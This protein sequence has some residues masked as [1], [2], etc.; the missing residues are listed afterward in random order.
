MTPRFA[1]LVAVYLGVLVALAVPLGRYV[2]RVFTGQNRTTARLLG[3]V[4]RAV[5]ALAHI[6]ATQEHPWRSY[7]MALV[8]FSFVTHLITYLVLRTQAF[9]PWNPTH[10]PNVP[11]WLAFNTTVGF[12]T[13]TAWESSSGE[14][15]VSALSQVLALVSQN[16]FAP[17]VAMCAAMALARG[18]ARHESPTVGNAWVDLVRAHLYVLVP[19]SIV[20]AIAFVSQGVVESLLGPAQWTTVD[21]GGQKLLR[22]PVAALEAIKLLGSNGEGYYNANSAHPWENPTALSNFVQLVAILILPAALCFTFGEMVQSRRHGAALAFA[23]AALVVVGAVAIAYF[24]QHGNPVLAGTGVAELSPNMEGKEVRFG[25]PDSAL[26]AEVTTAASCGAVD[27]MHD[28]YM[29]LGGLVP[30]L[31]MQVG[32]VVFGG[33]GCG[34]YGLIA[35][36][37]LTVFLAGLLIG[38]MP[39]YLGKKIEARDIRFAL[40]VILIPAFSIL[41]FTALGVALDAGRAGIGNLAAEQAGA[42]AWRPS[43][44]GLSEVLYAFSSA[45]A[46]NGSTFAGMTF[47]SP[48][49]PVFYS[50][51][52]ALAM[53]LGRYPILIA[54]LALAGSLAQKRRAAAED[55]RHGFPVDGVLFAGLLVT[56]VVIVGALTFSPALAFGPIVEHLLVTR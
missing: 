47:Y 50:V 35:F 22:G 12:E 30:M 7:A 49:H 53:F 45:S 14:A 40:L 31:N 41:I 13:G 16:F 20:F 11:P 48:E 8:G 32:E 39:E 33:T 36:V 4:E 2:A 17:A 15:T 6:D 18:L 19:L 24:E 29:P 46:N 25:V 52:L 38:R 37:L 9:L 56:V 44:H 51:T 42:P 21:G 23:V 10:L 3:P 43:P 27:S 26:F 1:L 5:Y 55:G 28:S 54:V 34:L